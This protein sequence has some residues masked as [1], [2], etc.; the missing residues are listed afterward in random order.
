MDLSPLHSGE[1]QENPNS[2]STTATP[3]GPDS[4]TWQLGL[5]RTALLVAGRGLLLQTMHPVVGAGVRDFSS[6]ASDPWGRL[7]RTLESLQV[8]L[9]G[10]PQAS[11]E[12]DRLRRLHAPMQGVG[13]SGERY[14]A[15]DRGAYM[16]VHLSNFDTLLS[17]HRWF[18]PPLHLDQQVTLYQEW[19]Q[20]GA[21]LGIRPDDM[22]PD[23][24]AFRTYVR[25]MVA[26]TL[27]DNE[28]ARRVL[29]SLRLD[30]VEAPPWAGLP[31]PLWSALRPLG[32]TL[33]RDTTVGTLPAAA[34]RRLGLPWSSLDRRRLQGVAVLVRATSAPLPDRLLHYPVGARARRAA[35]QSDSL[36][37][38]S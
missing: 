25:Q 4:L 24:G 11:A 7:D 18:A 27:T 1:T 26:T 34:R 38:A 10:G 36:G 5:P 28:T 35:R 22:P 2:R 9:F 3:L 15:L 20:V 32:R 29:A 13:F 12:A 14:R 31:R 37:V 17:F 30:G 16:W 23:L 33:L 19:R 8:Q 6:F 21:V